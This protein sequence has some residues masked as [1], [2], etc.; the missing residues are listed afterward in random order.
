MKVTESR[1]AFPTTGFC[2]EMVYRGIPSR[3]TSVHAP[4]RA[5]TS[6]GCRQTGL[7]RTCWQYRIDCQSASSQVVV[8]LLTSIVYA[9][10]ALLVVSIPNYIKIIFLHTPSFNLFGLFKRNVHFVHSKT[11]IIKKIK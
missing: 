11:Y 2:F 3:S 9:A 7:I 4:P 8:F 10:T 5:G 1:S 6:R